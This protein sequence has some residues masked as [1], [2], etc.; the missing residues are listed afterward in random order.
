RSRVKSRNL[1]CAAS[2]SSISTTGSLTAGSVDA[3]ARVMSALVNAGWSPR[4]NQRSPPARAARP[5]HA[6]LPVVDGE[7]TRLR[8]RGQVGAGG[9]RAGDR[10]AVRGGRDLRAVDTE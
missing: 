9:G 8:D 3:S 10:H 1:R 7:L 4:A 5:E 2:V 6:A